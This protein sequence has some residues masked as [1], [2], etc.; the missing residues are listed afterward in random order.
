MRTVGG[1][2]NLN[3]QYG[4]DL[5]IGIYE[6]ITNP[7][8]IIF[9]FVLFYLFV[10]Y[11][12]KDYFKELPSILVSIGIL[13]TFTGILIGL[14]NFDE[15]IL[16]V[17]VPKLLSGLKTAF[18]TSVLGLVLSIW[19]KVRSATNKMKSADQF[20]DDPAQVTPIESLA[21]IS[22][23]LQRLNKSIAGDKD[24]TILTQIQN[25]RLSFEEKFKEIK[26]NCWSL[27]DQIKRIEDQLSQTV[28]FSK[29]L[30]NSFGQVV[31]LLKDIKEKSDSL[32]V[33]VTLAP[34]L[35]QRFTDLITNNYTLI[36]VVKGNVNKINKIYGSVTSQNQQGVLMQLDKMNKIAYRIEN[37]LSKNGNELIGE[38]L[39]NLTKILSRLTYSTTPGETMFDIINQIEKIRSATFALL[40]EARKR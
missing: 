16:N 40:D 27:N 30:Y 29:N 31:N 14:L 37:H 13:G 35:E 39:D 10:R 28:S 9:S 38:N 24:S 22:L 25:F 3:I 17:S 7:I 32:Q 21:F 8:N 12:K 2:N 19:I 6:L 23:E 26:E 33:S 34:E 4:I 36:D 18:F 11:R 15:N 1:M 5:P 20:K